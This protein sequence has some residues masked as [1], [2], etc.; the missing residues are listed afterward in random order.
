MSLHVIAKRSLR[1]GLA[2]AL[3]ATGAT[4]VATSSASAGSDPSPSYG[5]NPAP[6]GSVTFIAPTCDVDTVTVHGT[7]ATPPGTYGGIVYHLSSNQVDE[8]QTEVNTGET[9]TLVSQPIAFGETVDFTVSAMLDTSVG[10]TPL[11]TIDTFSVTRPSESS[12]TPTPTPT[13]TETP[14]PTPTSSP[15]ATPTPTPVV[16]PTP[17]ATKPVVVPKKPAAVVPKV[18]STD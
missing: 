10:D 15:T 4:F 6:A 3:V 18:V 12:C 2:V 13:P 7:D 11:V 14:T 1:L 8:D 5:E 9:F 17:V 16:T